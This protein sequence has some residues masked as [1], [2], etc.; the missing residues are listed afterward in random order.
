MLEAKA[1]SVRFDIT[2]SLTAA[3]KE[4]ART[5]IEAQKDLGLYI[6]ADGY[7]CQRISSDT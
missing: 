2:Q 5:N 4:R 7:I 1:G 3:N 6:D